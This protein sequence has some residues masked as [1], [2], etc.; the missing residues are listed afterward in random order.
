M[1]SS[2]ASSLPIKGWEA[3]PWSLR[4]LSLP[5]KGREG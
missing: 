2:A 4:D 1:W 5:M 3:P